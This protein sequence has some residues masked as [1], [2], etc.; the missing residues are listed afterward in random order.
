[1]A[2]SDALESPDARLPAV[3]GLP[4]E[5]VLLTDGCQTANSTPL[6]ALPG[7]VAV[8]YVQ[9]PQT[10]QRPVAVIHR[11]DVPA[12]ARAGDRIDVS[13]DMQA[14]QTIEA[15]LRL[16]VD[17]TLVGDGPV[18]LDPGETHRSLPQRIDAAGFVE[19]RAELQV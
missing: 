9:L 7:G 12:V 5:L 18:H 1:T 17:G 6:D 11:L 10:T 4:P 8:S 19:I 14:A 15:R 13:L 16:W 2:R 3:A